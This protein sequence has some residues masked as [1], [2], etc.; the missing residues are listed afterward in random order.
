[1]AGGKCVASGLLEG[2]TVGGTE[3]SDTVWVVARPLVLDVVWNAQGNCRG[4][5]QGTYV[6]YLFM[7]I[8]MLA[9]SCTARFLFVCSVK[10]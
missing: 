8:K 7:R 5:L 6:A 3:D 10:Q 2:T 9:C 4:Q 1:M